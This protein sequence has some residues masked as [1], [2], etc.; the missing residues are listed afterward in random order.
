MSIG[1]RGAERI[2]IY[3]RESCVPFQSLYRGAKLDP[4]SIFQYETDN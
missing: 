1:D 2:L 3:R 4:L